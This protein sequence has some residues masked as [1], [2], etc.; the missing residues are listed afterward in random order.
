MLAGDE[1]VNIEAFIDDEP[2]RTSPCDC[3]VDWLFNPGCEGVIS[4]RQ[5]LLDSHVP[6]LRDKVKVPVSA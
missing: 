6:Y 3:S 5:V 4:L 2:P 1:G